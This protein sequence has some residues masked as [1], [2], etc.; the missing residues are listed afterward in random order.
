MEDRLIYI[1]NPANLVSFVIFIFWLGATRS[2]LNWKIKECEK[3]L[4]RLDELD[5]DSRLTQMQIDLDRVKKTLDELKS[6]MKK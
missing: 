5:L 6:M 2:K 4:D 1:T 3:R